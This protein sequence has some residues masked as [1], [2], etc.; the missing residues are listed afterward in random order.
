MSNRSAGSH[1]LVQKWRLDILIL[2]ESIG[3]KIELS[4][5][6]NQVLSSE[7]KS[8]E[9]FRSLMV[10]EYW[11]VDGAKT[12][13]GN[14]KIEAEKPASGGDPITRKGSVAVNTH[15]EVVLEF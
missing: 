2:N 6:G 7:L 12:V 15:K 5:D 11:V 13:A 4:R 10:E 1:D 8:G 14:Y 3:T 9:N